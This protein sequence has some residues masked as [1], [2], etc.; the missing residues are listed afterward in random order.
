MMT[1]LDRP[2]DLETLRVLVASTAHLTMHDAEMLSQELEH[3]TVHS[4][5]EGFWVHVPQGEYL[6]H[7]MEHYH[8]DAFFE[9][10]GFAK[11]LGYQ[12]LRID[13][14]APHID[15]LPVYGW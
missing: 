4:Y 12:W 6:E 11:A 7:A 15:A 3:I 2:S 8:F 13:R 5:T 1:T 9:L 10:V 14:D